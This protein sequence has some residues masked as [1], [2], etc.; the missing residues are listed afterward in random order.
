MR[1][2]KKLLF[3]SISIVLLIGIAAGL[4]LD[5]VSTPSQIT[6]G[7]EANITVNVGND[8][9]PQEN[10]TVNF[11]TTPPGIL[12]ENSASTDSSGVATITVNSTVAGIATINASV[13]SDYNSTNVTF[14]P[15]KPARIDVNVSQNTLVVGNT[16]FVAL[17]L[18]D[19]YNNINSTAEVD[20]NISI[21]DVLGKMNYSENFTRIPSNLTGLQITRVPSNPPDDPID[22]IGVNQTNDTNISSLQVV[23]QINSTLAGY[24]NVTA[25]S[26][27]VTN[28]TNIT[29]IPAEVN[30]LL[31]YCVGDTCNRIVNQTVNLFVQA[32]DI[33]GNPVNGTTVNF[34]ATPPD[35]TEYNSPIWYNTLNFTPNTST[36]HLD[37]NT[38]IVIFRT[39]KRA[40]DNIL[41]TSTSSVN[42]SDIISGFADVPANLFLSHSPDFVP[43]NSNDLYLLK[44]QVTDVFQNP[45]L[46]AGPPY[47]KKVHFY[48]SS[49]ETY[50]LLNEKGAATI[51][52]GPTAYIETINVSAFY[53]ETGYTDTSI[54]NNTNLSFVSGN[55]SR[56]IF[57]ANPDTVMY[58]N[59]KKD[60]H[61]ATIFLKALDEWGHP[62]RGVNVTLTNTNTT[63]GN[64]TADGVNGTNVI[65]KVTDSSG[66]IQAIFSSNISAGNVTIMAENVSSNVSINSSLNISVKDKT[67]ISVNI[68]FEPTNVSTGQPVNVTTII[69]VEGETP[70]SR[71]SANAMLVIDNSGSM[72]PDYYAGTALDIMLLID[73]SSS[74]DTSI[75]SQTKLNAAKNAAK[76]FNAN[77]IS[78]DRVG[79]YSF[80]TSVTKESDLS[81]NL[82]YINS[83]ITSLSASGYTSTA[84]AINDSTVNLK[85]N[86]RLGAR[87][88]IIL[89]SDGMPSQALDGGICSKETST[90]S[91]C[92]KPTFDAISEANKTKNTMI[93]G[94]KITLYAIGFGADA[95]NNTMAAIASPGCSYYAATAEELENIYN[96]IA[97]QISDFDI[98]TRQYGIDGFTLYN[99]STGI[100]NKSKYISYNIS[101]DDDVTDF[102]VQVDNPYVDF[103]LTSPS[104]NKIRYPRNGESGFVNRSGLYNVS[105]DKS[106][107]QYIW[108]EPENNTYD[109]SNDKNKLIPKGTWTLN[110]TTTNATNVT[111]N[112][113]TYIDKISAVKAGSLAF[114]SSF[115]ATRG[116]RAGL[117]K[118]SNLSKPTSNNQSSY[119]VNGSTWLGYF[120]NNNISNSTWI[121]NFPSSGNYYPNNNRSNWTNR[122]PGV[123]QIRVHFV[124]IDVEANHDFVNIS[125][126]NN[127]R[128]VSYTNLGLT[129]TSTHKQ[130]ANISNVWSPWVNGDTININFS[131]DASTNYTG[132][133]I[134][135]IETMINCTFN[136][137]W[138]NNT[139]ILDMNLYQ[140]TS[141]IKNAIR[142][143]NSSTL[144][145]AIYS[146]K[147]YYVEVKGTNV[148]NETNFT[149]NTTKNM[150]WFSYTANDAA[151]IELSNTSKSFVALNNAIGNMTADGLTA[152]DEG[153]FLANNQFTIN[154]TRPTIVIMT[155]G[156][157]NAGYRSLLDEAYR[158]RNN[159]TVI[160]TIGF[161]NNESEVDKVTLKKIANITGGEYK[162]AP[163]TTELKS[164]FQGFASNLVKF[165]ATD[166]TL[167]IR[168]PNNYISGFSVARLTYQNGSGNS[169]N[170]TNKSINFTI[171]IAPGKGHDPIPSPIGNTT[172]L[173]WPLP[174][175]TVGDKWG[176]W[177][178]LLVEGSGY[179]PLILEGS[180]ITY[181]SLDANQS[182]V[183]N[184]INITNA[185]GS[186]IGGSGANISYM[187]L[188]DLLLLA[189]PSEILRGEQSKITVSPKFKDGN[190]AIAR[191]NL[192]SNL[193]YFNNLENPLNDLIVSNTEVVNFTSNI[194]G[195]AQ[196]NVIARNGNNSV[197]GNVLVTVKPRG[198]I[199]VN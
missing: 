188:G 164:I 24:I 110:V 70:V 4:N 124:K 134:D 96:N 125:D 43:A 117:V 106:K 118:Y 88:I 150:N 16:S 15:D 81:Y 185:G 61:N 165:T 44:A 170:S 102:K 153:L 133:Q 181:F 19:I 41:Y 157:D 78:N 51:Q 39:D 37:G 27:G 184:I 60:N 121:V 38:N 182:I 56:F 25:S 194:A 6:V 79:L 151:P 10:I 75:G 138:P 145:A 196:I 186:D 86:I 87:P 143:G 130:G 140:G 172:L 112:V 109:P 48:P 120:E 13:G 135:K 127:S 12:S 113:T 3:I 99:Y 131:S 191:V 20:I 84:K 28:S 54:W 169:T 101:L 29:F 167:N 95:D 160:N 2:V 152:I 174:N 83:K 162:F 98:T 142:S 159:N 1:H 64:L 34:N 53:V 128:M 107:G 36:T 126:R 166:T 108:I 175:L 21:V 189:T 132:F 114:I 144:N 42:K 23:L 91:G 68:T 22:Q 89:L 100:A 179:I 46:Q 137:S 40:G 177:Y 103:N 7:G 26:K 115:D 73:T 129:D 190:P 192:S 195:Q 63:L 66:G 156:L 47:T 183:I 168:I 119:V 58:Q 198:R 32:I 136:L 147:S 94:Q 31:M 8:S 9:V 122:T 72:D 105:N 139:D 161:G 30:D 116:D 149:I 85:T 173:S 57:Y 90:Y 33:Y 50:V 178:Q 193:G 197:S 148:S 14:L 35:A 69:S 67:F 141:L 65:N 176:I 52:V 5:I 71:L 158:A 80:D 76:L 17:T 163:N 45:V 74:M 199:I 11:T 146:D 93:N 62:V 77:M 55:L 97:Q 111:F 180:N 123:D 49:I 171:P 187:E 18:Y 59:G 104:P 82:T 92:P 155:D 154:S